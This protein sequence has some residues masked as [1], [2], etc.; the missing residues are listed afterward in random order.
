MPIRRVGKK[1]RANNGRLYTSAKSA[2]RANRRAT[3]T[4]Q[5]LAAKK[6]RDKV[7]R[8]NKRRAAR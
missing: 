5:G 7:R 4:P 2:T 8:A 3:Q 1:W 6:R